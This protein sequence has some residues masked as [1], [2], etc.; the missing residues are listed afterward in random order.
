[1]HLQ[2]CF[3]HPACTL[4]EY[5]PWLRDCFEEPAT[6]EDGYFQRPMLPG[7]GTT[8]NAAALSKYGTS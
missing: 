4:L 1:V 8:L 5:I 2:L 7:A 6:V 3:A